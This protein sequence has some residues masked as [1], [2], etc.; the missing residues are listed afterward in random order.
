[1]TKPRLIVHGPGQFNND[2]VSFILPWVQPLVSQYFDIVEYSPGSTYSPATDLI[3]TFYAY[4]ETT[5]QPWYAELEQAGHRIVVDHLWDSD[6]AL[7]PYTQ[8]NQLIMHCPNWMWYLSCREFAHYGHESYVPNRNRGS[9]FLMLMNNP[10]W[11]RDAII[12]MLH[13]AIDHAVYSYNSQGRHLDNDRPDSLSIG[14]KAV[15]W[16]RYMNP[17]WYDN[18]AF[19]VVVES[20]MRNTIHPSGMRTEVSE[21]I[22]KPLAYWHPFVVAGS[23][24]TLQ[25]LK[26]QGFAT[27]DNLFDESY[28]HILDDRIRLG[29]VC[30]TIDQI[31][32]EW[33]KYSSSP[34]E[35]PERSVET[36]KRVEHNHYHFFNHTYVDQQII[37]EI[38][39]PMLQYAET[40]S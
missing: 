30:N 17:Q 2:S 32:K 9:A 12:P 21:K 33:Q 28:D 8:G 25:Y 15:S 1:M 11:H 4:K 6:V 38:I 34:T 37:K 39:E 16:Q 20:Y 10:R 5:A 26:A 19:S 14:A 27:F 23:V 24:D 35:S 36:Q 22:F 3:G 31:T 40:N 29:T 18:T 7:T 13:N